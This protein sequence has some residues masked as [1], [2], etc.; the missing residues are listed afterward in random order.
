[1]FGFISKVIV[2]G[3]GNKTLSEGV[4]ISKREVYLT[5]RM[6]DTL[7]SF[8]DNCILSDSTYH[9]FHESNEL[10]LNTLYVYASRIFDNP[11]LFNETSA[12]IAKSLYES[13]DH[14]KI[15][16][17]ELIVVLFE[18]SEYE[19]VKCR[20]LG[21]FKSESKDKYLDIDYQDDS[22][23]F[24]E[25][26]GLSVD[27][28]EKGAVIY[29]TEKDSGFRVKIVMRSSKQVD[30]KYWMND[31]LHVKQLSDSF[32]KTQQVVALTKRFV[33][34]VLD[35]DDTVPRIERAEIVARASAF[36]SSNDTFD[37]N[38]FCD[39]VFRDKDK[40]ENFVQY[41]DD[42]SSEDKNTF[43]IPF[44]IDKQLIKKQARV[45]KSVIKLDKN[46]HIYVHGGEGMIKRGYD[47]K[48]GMEYY[49]L[50]FMKEE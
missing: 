41:R 3:V 17:G 14:P 22:Y 47:E 18:K 34:D 27:C 2:H 44:K 37:D 50:F 25:N 23:S 4:R 13:S 31:F 38:S 12:I 29:N 24:V 32:F 1:M 26:E 45:F 5:E 42:V 28:I 21:L 20:A 46:F 40:I 9:F 7:V 36:L 11:V 48:T 33:R 43:A 19:G 8:F 6:N 49:Q 35:E 30:A 39:M 15:H 16:S 10:V